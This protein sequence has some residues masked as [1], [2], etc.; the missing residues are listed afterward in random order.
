[1]HVPI[2]VGLSLEERSAK[3]RHHDFPAVGAEFADE[4]DA[5]LAPNGD[6]DCV[7][8]K[9]RLLLDLAIV[10]S[11]VA[12][13][14]DKNEAGDFLFQAEFRKKRFL[15]ETLTNRIGILGERSEML[16]LLGVGRALS[17]KERDTFLE[18][19]HNCRTRTGHLLPLLSGDD[20]QAFLDAQLV[21]EIDMTVR[22]TGFHGLSSYDGTCT[23]TA[24]DSDPITVPHELE[25]NIRCFIATPYDQPRLVSC[26][27]DP[28][29]LIDGVQCEA[30]FVS[31]YYYNLANPHLHARVPQELISPFSA[32]WVC[33]GSR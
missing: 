31:E 17:T 8:I 9:D 32:R 14:F 22:Q 20:M 18:M 33:T 28:T 25:H 24:I 6:R 10:A 27:T 3:L 15:R 26:G 1:M 13:A 21:R 12:H 11:S 16:S 2:E 19:H 7:L 4:I 23:Y 5:I 29:L 30:G